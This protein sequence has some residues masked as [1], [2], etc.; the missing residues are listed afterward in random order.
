[1]NPKVESLDDFGLP[2]CDKL[3]LQRVLRSGCCESKSRVFDD[4]GLP[5]LP[6]IGFQRAKSMGIEHLAGQLNIRK[7]WN[8]QNWDVGTIEKKNHVAF[9][10]WFGLSDTSEAKGP[11]S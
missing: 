2:D 11:S 5:E 8:D 4:F 6:P 10:D 7:D 3:D 1:M 9:D